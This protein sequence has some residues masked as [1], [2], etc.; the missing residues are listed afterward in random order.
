MTL[1][2]TVTSGIFMLAR[3]EYQRD[4]KL[5]KRRSVCSHHSVLVRQ[6]H[7]RRIPACNN[8]RN[9]Y[10]DRSIRPAG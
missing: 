2:K 3:Y 8:G 4:E 9:E 7:G 6:D 10:R 1:E 5:R